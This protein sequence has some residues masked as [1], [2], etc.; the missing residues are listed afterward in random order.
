MDMLFHTSSRFLW[1]GYQLSPVNVNELPIWH[2]V[3]FTALAIILSFIP[4]VVG[5]V[6][7]FLTQGVSLA[8]LLSFGLFAEMVITLISVVA[9]MLYIR[10]NKDTRL[11]I[12]INMLMFSGISL[13]AG[14]TFTH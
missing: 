4:I 10:I 9:L 6:H 7:L 8:V 2:L 14:F 3:G 12:P 1:L 5:E 13:V 11:K